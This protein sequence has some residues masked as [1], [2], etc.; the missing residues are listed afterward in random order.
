MTLYDIDGDRFAQVMEEIARMGACFLGG[1]A[2]A[3]RRNTFRK[4]WAAADVPLVWPQAR[5]RTVIS[6]LFPGGVHRGKDRNHRRTD[7]SHR[8]IQ[9]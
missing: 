4:P 5:K 2:A 7:Q 8:Q 9:V 6:S 3:L 1:A